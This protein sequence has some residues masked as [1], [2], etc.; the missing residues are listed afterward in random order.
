MAYWVASTYA[1]LG[2]TDLAF[3]WFSRAVKLGNENK[4]HFDRDK[5]LDSLRNDP[6]FHELMDKMGSGG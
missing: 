2:E 3:K 4:P 5:S 1:L 6:R